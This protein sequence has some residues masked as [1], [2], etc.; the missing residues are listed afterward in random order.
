MDNLEGF[1]TTKAPLF[2]GNNFSF[3]SVRMETYLSSLGFDVWE[4]VTQGYTFPSKG[5]SIADEKKSYGSNA[6]AKNSL[7]CGLANGIHVKVM[8]CKSANEVWDKL[9]SIYEGD[10][11]IKEAKLQTL[12]ARFESLKMNDDVKIAEYLLTIDETV[13]SMRGLGEQVE[14]K[15]IV[16]R[17]LRSLPSRFDSK[18]F[19]IE[20]A[21]DLKRFSID[22]LRGSLT[23]YE[24]RKQDELPN[25]KEAAFKNSKKNSI[26]DSEFEDLDEKELNLA[27]KLKRGSRKYKGKIIFKYFSYGKVGHFVAKC[28]YDKFENE[29]EDS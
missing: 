20:G 25:S 26:T 22:E 1:S 29:N 8:H 5:P 4:L 9:V 24:M 19:A 7:L 13:N 10:E 16:K 23:A 3:W 11:K 12:R 17:V 28:P 21:K 15:T 6:K 2:D 18:V 14:D 27:R